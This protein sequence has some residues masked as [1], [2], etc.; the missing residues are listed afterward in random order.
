MNWDCH[1]TWFPTLR[2]YRCLKDGSFNSSVEQPVQCPA[3][4]R[5]TACVKVIKKPRIRLM[6]LVQVDIQMYADREA[7]WCTYL[8]I[9][10]GFNIKKTERTGKKPPSSHR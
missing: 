8:G 5:A 10:H 1:G 9:E 7:N 3:C 4:G 6:A 2:T